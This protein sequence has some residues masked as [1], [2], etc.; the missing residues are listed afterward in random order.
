[1]PY[2]IDD[3]SFRYSIIASSAGKILVKNVS[4]L[5]EEQSASKSNEKKVCLVG[6]E[7]GANMKNSHLLPFVTI[8]E[9]NIYIAFGIVAGQFHPSHSASNLLPM[10]QE[11]FA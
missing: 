5:E 8:A 11:T 3:S 10:A 1:M 9:N 6:A 7:P 2:W 4:Q